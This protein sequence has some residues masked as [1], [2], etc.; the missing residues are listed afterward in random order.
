MDNIASRHD[1]VNKCH[2][3]AN[4]VIEDDDN[5]VVMMIV[6][7][8]GDNIELLYSTTILCNTNKLEL[9]CSFVVRD[10]NYICMFLTQ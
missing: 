9:A 8:I 5:N 2:S 6:I 7:M 4:T 3:K 1:K 10:V